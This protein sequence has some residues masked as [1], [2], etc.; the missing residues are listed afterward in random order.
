MSST[1]SSPLRRL[2][3]RPLFR[4]WAVVNLLARLPMTM[5]LLAL[6]LVGEAVTGSL[7][8]GASLAGIATVSAGLAAQWRGRMLD[9]VELRDGLRRHLGLSAITVLALLGA[10]AADAPFAVLA[11][12]VAVQGVASA[13][14]L[15]AFRTLLVECVPKE[16]LEPANALDAVFVEVAFVAGPAVA[17]VL[18]LAVGPLGVLVTMVTSFVVAALMLGGLPTREPAEPGAT[19]GPAP[20]RTRGATAVYALVF[21][22]G[23]PLGAW[24]AT[25]P[26]R[27][28]AFGM[29]P[30]SAGPLMALAALGSGIAGLAAANLRDPL[31]YGRLMASALLVAFGLLILPTAHATS[32]PLLGLAIFGFGLPIAPLNAL[33]GLA[34]QRTVATP[35]RA[36]GFALYPAMILIGAGIGQ[37]VAGLLLDRVGAA[38]LIRMLAV[39]PI[40]VAVPVLGAALRRRLAG[41]PPGVGFG[42]DPTIVDPDSWLAAAPEA[43][44]DRSDTV[45]GH[46]T[47]PVAPQADTRENLDSAQPS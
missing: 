27:I 44:V 10:A 1:S 8:N 32:L 21:A 25:I 47:A 7:A 43:H 33:A 14:I 39:V 42:H 18:A 19:R 4:R 37:T 9:R 5:N 35:R 41:L 46:R 24:E 28:E 26:A 30:A 11:V 12:L 45:A 38:S 29:D 23:L 20:L 31:R 13:A 15:G 17:G 3:R 6:V 34:F 2:L 16:D 22:T 40:L 36:E